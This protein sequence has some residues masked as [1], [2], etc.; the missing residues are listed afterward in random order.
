MLI[1]GDREYEI[2]EY[3]FH[4]ISYTQIM[5]EFYKNFTPVNF[6]KNIH[7]QYNCRICL[8][9]IGNHLQDFEGQYMPQVTLSKMKALIIEDETDIGYLLSNILKQRDVQSV[10]ASSLSEAEKILQQDLPPPIIFLDNHLPDGFGI[11]YIRK[12]KK[13]YPASKIVMITAYDNVS[14]RDKARSE[15]V[16]FFIGKPFSKEIIFKTIDSL[17]GQ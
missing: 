10:L 2:T 7:W 8:V 15:G 11:N 5:P 13:R 9:E 4:I 14:D 17:F 1:I 6:N 16:D 12:I 3:N